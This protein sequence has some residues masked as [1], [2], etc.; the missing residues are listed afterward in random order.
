M[1][2]V[3][4]CE[5]DKL[6]NEI[7]RAV[8]YVPYAISREHPDVPVDV[9]EGEGWPYRY[10]PFKKFLVLELPDWDLDSELEKKLKS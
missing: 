1:W 4:I 7:D 9:M 5:I 10:G 8:R 3:Q 2:L 6:E